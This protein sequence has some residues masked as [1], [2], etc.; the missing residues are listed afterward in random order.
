VGPKVIGYCFVEVL[1]VEPFVEWGVLRGDF[2]DD[3]VNMN[4]RKVCVYFK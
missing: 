2:M 3:L 4:E 1:V